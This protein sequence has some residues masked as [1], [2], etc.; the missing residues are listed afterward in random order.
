MAWDIGA[1]WRAGAFALLLAG[2]AQPAI[3][4]QATLPPADSD[5]MKIDPK[6]DPLV[7]LVG[8]IGLPESFRGA[9][10]VAVRE[11][12]ALEEARAG[13][14]EA[15][16]ARSEARAQR[17]PSGELNLSSFRTLSRDFSNDPQNI[18]ERS[19]S[20]QRTDFTLS[21]Q[22]PVFDFGATAERIS[23]AGARIESAEDNVASVAD[24]VA[25][26]AIAAWYDVFAYRSLLQIGDAYAESQKELREAVDERIKQGVSAPGDVAE[27]DSYLAVTAGRIASYRRQLANAEARFQELIGTPPPTDMSGS[28][29]AVVPAYERDIVVAAAG[30]SP[31]VQAAYAEARAASKDAESVRSDNLPQL[32]AGIDAGRYGV[33]ETDRD[34]DVRAR[35][36][37]RYRLF[38]GRNSRAN[39]AQARAAT[40]EARAQRTRIEAERDALIAWSDVDSL[41]VARDAQQ[42]SYVASRL[43]RDVLAE[44]FRVSRG[45][46]I[47]VLQAEDNFFQSAAQYILSEVELETARY[48]LMSRMGRLLPE[49]DIQPDSPTGR[50]GRRK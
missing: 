4:Q 19:R 43:S 23:A 8:T 14:A 45:T 38:G 16:A 46:L 11:H 7:G 44:R 10:R 17:F 39:Q 21:I 35:V 15:V 9:V 26:R 32:S 6:S 29:R 50:A 12:P 40:A 48:A 33:F 2:V 47:S 31:A 5:P 37:L 36:N 49:L 34:Y 18:I 24:Q 13:R 22:Q 30:Q 20:R 25:L 42:R 3:A 28:D 27:V 1:G 41:E